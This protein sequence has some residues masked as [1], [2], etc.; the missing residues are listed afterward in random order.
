MV[1]ALALAA[2]ERAG[3]EEGGGGHYAPGAFA[4]CAD[5]L[6]GRPCLSVANWFMYY[7]GSAGASRELPMGGQLTFGTHAQVYSDLVLGIYE[8]PLKLLGGDYA[9][10]LGLPYVWMEVDGKVTGPLGNTMRMRDTANGLGDLAVLPFM[11]GWTHGDLKYSVLLAV[12]APS[13]DYDTGQLANLGKNYWTFEPTVSA[14]W[15]SKKIGLE[16]TVFA[17]LDFSTKNDATDYQSGDVFHLELTVAEHLPL[18]NLGV[19]GLGANAFYYQQITG[20]S[21]RFSPVLGDFEGRTVGVG[22]VVSF[23]T[24]VCG[25]DLVAEVKWL[26]ELDVEKRLKG[27]YVW[28]KLGMAF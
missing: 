22:P 24:K 5:T 27:D 16:A 23:I 9:A 18:G 14:S 4:S 8:T 3:A 19:I 21:S 6:P 15:I 26:P 17:A 10:G 13:G 11:L 7:D 28:F 20:D 2:V 1:S 12:Y 25:Q